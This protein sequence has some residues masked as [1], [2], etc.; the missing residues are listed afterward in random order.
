[1]LQG[2][3]N[4]NHFYFWED[5]YFELTRRSLST[6]LMIRNYKQA[7]AFGAE[8]MGQGVSNNLQTNP[9]ANGFE[10]VG[11]EDCYFDERPGIVQ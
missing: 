3:K 6:G 1:M 7:A 8:P 2:V 11:C 10:Y 9:E 5:F 4:D